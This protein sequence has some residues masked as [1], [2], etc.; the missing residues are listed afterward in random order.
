MN[1]VYME[2]YGCQMNVYDSE[3]VKRILTDHRF[4]LAEKPEE[5]SIIFLNTCSV[6]E[7]AQQKVFQRLHVLKKLKS[8][9]KELIIGVLGCMAQSMRQELLNGKAGVDIIAGPD[10]YKRLPD[11]IENFR[12]NGEKEFELTLSEY[13]TYS[14]IFP[15]PDD[16]VN[17]WIAVMRGCNNFCTFCIVPYTRGRERSRDPYNILQETQKLAEQGIKQVTLLGQNV[18]SYRYNQYDFADLMKI[19]S[20]VDDIKRIRFTSP[21]HKD[22]PLKLLKV[23]AENP[24]ICKHIHLPLQAG[25][26]RIL[27]L[28]NRTY[29]KE[30]FLDL[31]S[32]I[33]QMMPDITLTTDIIVG[34]PTETENDFLD[35]LDVI[36]K[37]EFDA[38]FMFKYSERKHTI[39]SR[40][41]PDDV[42]EEEKSSR[43]IE[44]VNLQKRIAL[45]KNRQH[46]GHIFEVL[47]EG[48]GKKPAQLLGRND[49]NKI[50][51]FPGNGASNGDMVSVK[52]EEATANTLIGSAV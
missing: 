5:A 16:D 35:T 4:E 27:D 31:V 37:V 19:I 34:F 18:N 17:A 13:E 42:P 6:R 38:A 45:K 47:V 2:T 39:A 9:N 25:N 23:M 20:E 21:H 50:V 41:Y 11:L 40:K 28:M 12:L 48:K 52:I 43:L 29:S 7:N 36:T 1:K 26:T 51:V 22:F 24:K 10:S 33:R 3:I 44:L 32:L 15:E 8:N 49:G 30:E 46:I 14:D